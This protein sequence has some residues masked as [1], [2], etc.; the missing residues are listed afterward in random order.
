M[1]RPLDASHID[2]DH[3][4]TKH[5]RWL[6]TVVYARVNDR[7]AANDVMQEV[8]LAAIEANGKSPL[9][10]RNRVAP[11]LYRVAIHQTLLFKRSKGRERIK[12]ERYCQRKQEVDA[13]SGTKDPLDWLLAEER[14]AIL[15]AALETLDDRDRELLLL[16]YTEDWSY[17][18]IAEHIG[19]HREYR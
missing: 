17:A 14:N 18:Q 16:K 7:D 10:D 11:W 13:S 6:R 12:N 1:E 3:E 4:F 15:I 9:R 5:N 8:A 2:W 19:V